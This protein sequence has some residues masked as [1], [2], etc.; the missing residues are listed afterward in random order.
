MIFTTFSRNITLRV[1]PHIKQLINSVREN[2]GKTNVCLLI[3]ERRAL[4]KLQL[5]M[6]KTRESKRNRA[7]IETVRAIDK[8]YK[9]WK[10]HNN[11]LA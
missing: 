3:M 10:H 5:V 6:K 11:L 9:T 1:V 4:R 2:I 7:K 8:N